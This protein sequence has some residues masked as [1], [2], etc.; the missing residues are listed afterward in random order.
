MIEYQKILDKNM[1]K[2]G[3]EKLIIL[4][5]QERPTERS[6]QTIHIVEAISF[7]FDFGVY[8]SLTHCLHSHQKMTF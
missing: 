7:H 8:F 1:Q 6:I 2:Q 5:P 3:C 4:Y